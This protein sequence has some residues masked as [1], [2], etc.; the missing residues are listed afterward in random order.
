MSN[1]AILTDKAMIF[2]PLFEFPP[3]PKQMFKYCFYLWGNTR[4][5]QNIFEKTGHKYKVMRF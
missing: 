5:I 4:F 3:T 2:S 1:L